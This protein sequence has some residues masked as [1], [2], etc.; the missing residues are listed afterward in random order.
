MGA[1]VRTFHVHRAYLLWALPLPLAAVSRVDHA[2]TDL[3]G[4]TLLA[5][6]LGATLVAAVASY[7]LVEQ[8]IRR[9]RLTRS[10]RG[11]PIAAG[12][13]VATAAIVVLATIAPAVA[14]IPPTL[15]KGS[16]GLR[17]TEHEQ[18]EAAHAFTTDPIRFLMFG[19]SVA[20]TASNGLRIGDEGR[21]GVRLINNGVLGCDLD[22]GPSILGGVTY[23]AAPTQNC[24]P[25]PMLFAR[26][27][28]KYDPEVV[29]LLIGRFEVDDH[30]RNGQVVHVGQPAWDAHLVSQLNQAIRIF[31]ARGAHVVIFTFPYIDPPV[32][33]P[34]GD[35]WPENLPS[36]V[37]VWNQ[38]IRE[39]VAENPKTTTLIDLNRILDPDGHYTYEVDGI[40]V[41]Y[42]NDGI[43]IS[44]AGGLWLQPKI[45][46]EVAE[47][48]LAVR[49][50]ESAAHTAAS[51][52]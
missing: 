39:A 19:D 9:G 24:G 31:T 14:A 15:S 49:A 48:G 52:Q 5:A 23:P 50:K 11:L 22:L 44:V 40:A 51:S 35:P 34:N 25:W 37:D 47:L 32:E 16:A 18:L 42:P 36:R 33:Q 27:V 12:G 3:S 17:P 38:L 13:A 1:R 45:L 26:Q 6:R 29:G 8:P 46:P 7:H 28:A 43:H 20:L 4:A 10:W 41:R 2:H 21:Y 30:I